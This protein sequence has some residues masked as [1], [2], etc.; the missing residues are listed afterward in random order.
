[1][2]YQFKTRLA[3]VNTAFKVSVLFI[4]DSVYC[5]CLE[6]YSHFNICLFLFR[7]F[8]LFWEVECLITYLYPQVTCDLP[9]IWSSS[10]YKR[11][12]ISVSISMSH[13]EM[14]LSP[15]ILWVSGE[16]VSPYRV[17]QRFCLEKRINRCLS[18]FLPYVFYILIFDNL[19]GFFF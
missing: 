19:P 9:L 12:Q 17:H 18:V 8:H 5:P 7:P 2:D 6:F 3:L 10:A 11:G 13:L 14:P 16:Q 1:M 15:A 4:T